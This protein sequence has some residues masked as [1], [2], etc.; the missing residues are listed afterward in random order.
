MKITIDDY[1]I[2]NR[3]RHTRRDISGDYPGDRRH[4]DRKATPS[5][6]ATEVN[7]DRTVIVEFED[8]DWLAGVVPRT[9]D[10][11]C[12]RNTE[13]TFVELI[14]IQFHRSAD[15]DGYN[16]GGRWRLSM[17]IVSGANLKKDGQPGVKPQ[18]VYFPTN[19]WTEVGVWAEAD[20]NPL[21]DPESYT[22]KRERERVGTP[23]FDHVADP[24]PGWVQDIVD[25]A[26][27]ETGALPFQY[28]TLHLFGDYADRSWTPERRLSSM[29]I[30][31]TLQEDHA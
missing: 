6:N 21:L 14:E 22:G 4:W 11:A 12:D 19:T 2:E 28:T 23:K 5:A 8:D 15:D 9:L 24:L 31:L 27:P 10:R 1:R 13:G 17:I 30:D 7:D 20:V 18:T 16:R 25:R 29:V 3:R 26:H